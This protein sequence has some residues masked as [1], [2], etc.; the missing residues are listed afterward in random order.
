ME[1]ETIRFVS[2]VAQ[3]SNIFSNIE[4]QAYDVLDELIEDDDKAYEDTKN[5]LKDV[6]MKVKADTVDQLERV[7]AVTKIVQAKNNVNLNARD[8]YARNILDKVNCLS[9]QTWNRY[10]IISSE[11]SKWPSTIEVCTRNTYWG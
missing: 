11:R 2:T 6:R 7:H 9:A 1:V 8:Q 3:D 4:D 5:R 10:T